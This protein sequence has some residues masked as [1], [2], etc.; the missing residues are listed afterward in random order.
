[1]KRPNSTNATKNMK[2]IRVNVENLKK[3][4]TYIITLAAIMVGC[5]SCDKI[6]NRVNELEVSFSVSIGKDFATPK[7]NEKKEDTANHLKE[8][9]EELDKD[10]QERPDEEVEEGCAAAEGAATARNPLHLFDAEDYIQ[11]MRKQRNNVQ[12]VVVLPTQEKEMSANGIEV[13]IYED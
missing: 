9:K 4:I 13:T 10:T 11:N 1:M 8:Q 2:E 12:W 5:S 6:Q 7:S 3:K